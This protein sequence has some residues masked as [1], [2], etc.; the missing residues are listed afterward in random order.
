MNT[1]DNGAALQTLAEGVCM[2]IQC[3]VDEPDKVSVRL[4]RLTDKDLLIVR[5]KGQNSYV[6]G[7]QGKT[8]NAFKQII[9]SCSGALKRRIFI[10]IDDSED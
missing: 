9:S 3:L 10:E 6:F 4:E 1:D 7:N 8:F 5:T 2:V